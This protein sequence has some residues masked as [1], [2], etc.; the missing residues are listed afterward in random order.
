MLNDL[1][2]IIIWFQKNYGELSQNSLVCDSLESVLIC[3]Q[4][5]DESEASV[6]NF[7][8]EKLGQLKY[9]YILY[10]LV[11]ILHSLAML[12]K[13]F[14]MKFVDVITVGSIMRTEVAQICMMFIVDSYDLNADVFNEFI[15]YHVLLDYGPHGR[16]LKRLQSE[17]RVSMFHNFQMTWSRFG[18]DLKKTLM[19]Q[20]NFTQAVYSALDARFYDN[21]LISYFKILNPNNMPSMQV[22][23]QNWCIS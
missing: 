18:I 7:I 17:V 19:V 2:R 23:L 4:E 10:F 8:L 11:D 5:V 15:G 12:S 22:G 6:A 9:F 21:D 13:I 14:Q 20:K 3:F 1:A 16:Y